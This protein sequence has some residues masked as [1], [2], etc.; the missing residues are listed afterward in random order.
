[1]NER[2]L[3]YHCQGDVE[4]IVFFKM[5]KILFLGE[6]FE[7]VST[8]AKLLYMI[9]LDRV[10][11]SVKNNWVDKNNRVFI[12]YTQTEAMEKL[13][14]GNKKVSNLFKELEK[15]DLINRVKQG[16][17]QPD[18]IYVKTL[19]SVKVE[20][21]SFD[22][23]YKYGRP[24]IEHR[25]DEKSEEVIALENKIK[26][27]EGKLDKANKELEL[28]R[29]GQNDM[30]SIDPTCQNDMS[31]ID[32]TCQNDITSVDWTC[33]N[34]ISSSDPTCQNDTLGDVKTTLQEM[35]KRHPNKNNINNNN[36]NNNNSFILSQ[37]ELLSKELN[38]KE[39]NSKEN[40]GM[41]ERKNN[42]LNK[43]N[44]IKEIYDNQ[45]LPYSFTDS[46]FKM[47]I[48]IKEL[49]NYDTTESNFKN[50]TIDEFYF[51]TYKLFTNALTNMVTSKANMLLNGEIVTYS[52]AYYKLIEYISFEEDEFCNQYCHLNNLVDNA[53]NDYKRASTTTEIKYPQK[54]MQACI[55]NALQI[56]DV[57]MHS[58]INSMIN[59]TDQV[60]DVDK[61]TKQQY[62]KSN[63]S[64]DLQEVDDMWNSYV[65]SFI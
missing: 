24:N 1:M 41:K 36:I 50:N 40:N 51:S 6:D 56:G 26:L 44:I 8:S 65:P 29:N 3:N 43:L 14:F 47:N 42:K 21:T 54:Y 9:L 5:P 11:I 48:A 17:N 52:K 18:L 57:R 20:D 7:E 15:F 33:Q 13:N 61:K 62:S 22:G 34:D 49:V 23:E 45:E 64:Y 30:S 25:I 37:K 28:N 60:G 19:S 53:I 12:Y 27:L 31:S 16:Y 39:L 55:W 4:E 10:S 32:W 38:S 58:E 46:E 2:K 63:T 59:D 35:S